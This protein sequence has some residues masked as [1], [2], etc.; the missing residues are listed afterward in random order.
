MAIDNK[1]ISFSPR[2]GF[3]ISPVMPE[4][5]GFYSCKARFA[6]RSN[7]YDVSLGVLPRTSYVPPPHINR[8]SGSHVTMGKTLVLTCS[9][10]VSWSVMVHLD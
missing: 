1:L 9:V 8:T 2:V 7:E 5:A 6:G 4:H 10:S 3:L